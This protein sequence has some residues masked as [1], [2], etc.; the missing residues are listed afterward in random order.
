MLGL[1]LVSLL[2]NLQ[3]IFL[4]VLKSR[5]WGRTNLSLNLFKIFHDTTWHALRYFAT[6][7]NILKYFKI[8][9]ILFEE[10]EPHFF[11]FLYVCL[12]CYRKIAI[13]LVAN[14]LWK[15]KQSSTASFVFTRQ[16]TSKK[17]ECFSMPKCFSDTFFIHKWCVSDRAFRWIPEKISFPPRAFSSNSLASALTKGLWKME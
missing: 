3:S 5:Y 11:E 4:Y 9:Y 15:Q 10:K 1:N 12:Y 16:R 6:L 8:F 17:A 2:E 7:C 14:S 13:A